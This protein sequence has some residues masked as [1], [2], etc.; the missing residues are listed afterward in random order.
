MKNLV[1]QVNSITFDSEKEIE[2]K[3]LK[4]FLH[5]FTEM[6]STIGAIIIIAIL[7]FISGINILYIFVPIY[8]FQLG[9][10][11]LLKLLFSKPRPETHKQKNIFG[12]RVTSGSFP[13]GHTSNIFCLAFLISNFYQLNII[14]TLL[15]FI[16]AGSV[17]FSRIIL[18]RHYVIDVVA[19]AFCGLIFS[20]I[21]AML[22]P[23]LLSFVI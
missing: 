4:K 15:I 9:M 23:N 19:G 21:G 20:V 13:S 18:G 10:V 12:I 16:V 14:W 7:A 5:I 22:L 1:G 11:E 2:S 17:A 6:G 3:A 8:L